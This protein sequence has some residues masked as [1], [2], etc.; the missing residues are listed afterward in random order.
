MERLGL[1][2]RGDL[3]FDHPRVADSSPLKRHIVYETAA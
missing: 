3:D 2:R 1:V